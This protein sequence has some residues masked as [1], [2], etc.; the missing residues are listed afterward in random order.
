MQQLGCA[1]MAST[2]KDAD[3]LRLVLEQLKDTEVAD[4][5]PA[6]GQRAGQLIARAVLD[7]GYP[8]L[9]VAPDFRVWRSLAVVFSPGDGP[10]KR[11]W[12]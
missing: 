11:R 3:G 6:A 4:A 9:W 1:R 12:D 10:A 8:V 5:D 7:Q 2:R